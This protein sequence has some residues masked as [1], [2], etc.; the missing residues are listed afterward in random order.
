[1]LVYFSLLSPYLALLFVIVRV[2]IRVVVFAG[3]SSEVCGGG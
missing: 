2:I 3:V 1:V